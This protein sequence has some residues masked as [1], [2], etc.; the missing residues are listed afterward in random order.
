LNHIS[1][2]KIGMQLAVV[3]KEQGQ[4]QSHRHRLAEIAGLERLSKPIQER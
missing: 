4:A 2:I 1:K 3:C